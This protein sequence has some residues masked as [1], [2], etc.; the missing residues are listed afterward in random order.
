ML[1]K[2]ILFK[3]IFIIFIFLIVFFFFYYRAYKDYQVQEAYPWVLQVHAY[4]TENSLSFFIWSLQLIGS[5]LKT[6]K[7]LFECSSPRLLASFV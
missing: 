6:W 3:N 2:N 1:T 7:S 4:E 5:D